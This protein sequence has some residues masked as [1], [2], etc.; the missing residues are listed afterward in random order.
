MSQ[1]TSRLSIA[2]RH[3]FT[4]AHLTVR[5]GHRVPTLPQAH[6]RGKYQHPANDR[7]VRR[8]RCGFH[9]RRRRCR[10]KAAVPRPGSWQVQRE[11]N[12]LVLTRK[13]FKPLLLFLLLFAFVWSSFLVGWY[14]LA[15]DNVDGVC[16]PLGQRGVDELG[17]KA[18]TRIV[19]QNIDTVIR[20]ALLR[21]FGGEMSLFKALTAHNWSLC[22]TEKRLYL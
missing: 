13:W 6:C 22:H 14:S 5:D 12:A 18:Y 11:G 21:V 15:G 9:L 19:D 7:Q 4:P 10:A 1:I 20:Q 16:L 8:M 2:H 17:V 3:P